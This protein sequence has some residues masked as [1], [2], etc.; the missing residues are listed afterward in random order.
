MDVL[1]QRVA[2]HDQRKRQQHLHQVMVDATHQG[3]REPA[4]HQ[5]EQRAAERLLGQQQHDVASRELPRAGGYTGQDEEHHHRHT[6]V[7]Q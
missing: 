2:A 5:P 7:E 4:E 6:V 3:E 1:G